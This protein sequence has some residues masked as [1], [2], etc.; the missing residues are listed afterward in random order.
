MYAGKNFTGRNFIFTLCF[1]SLI[2]TQFAYAANKS[3]QKPRKWWPQEYSV[4]RDEASGT[5]TVS[6]SYYTIVH[7][8]KKGGVITKIKYTN[9]KANNLLLKPLETSVRIADGSNVTYS[10]LHNSEPKVTHTKTDKSEIVITECSLLDK[11]GKDFG[12]KVK[13]KYEY[14]WGYIKIHKELHCQDAPQKVNR[15]TVLNTIFDPSLTKYGYREAITEQEGGGNY[16]FGT[17]QWGIMRPGT[18]FDKPLQTR[19]IPMQLLLANQGVEAIE[20]FA[21]SDLSQWDY[22][23]TGQPGTGL[24][25]I[26]QSLNPI[27][28]EVSICPVDLPRGAIELKGTYTFDYFIGMSILEAHATEPLFHKMFGREGAS[29]TP[30]DEIKRWANRGI[31]I[32]TFQDACHYYGDKMFWRDG[33]YPPYPPEEMKKMDKVIETSHRHGIKVVPYF[34]AKELHPSADEFKKH[35]QQWGTKPTDDG[36]LIHGYYG[37]DE[38]GVRMCLKSGWL[39]YLKFSIDRVLKNHKFNGA[40]F[41]WCL[42]IFCNNPLHMGKTTNNIPSDKGLGALAI[43]PTGHWDVEGLIELIEWTRQRIGPDGVLIIHD[44]QIPMLTLENFATHILAFEWGYNQVLSSFPHVSQMPLEWNLVGATSRGV[45]PPGVI[46]PKAPKR[47]NKLMALSALMTQVTVEDWAGRGK[48]DPEESKPFRIL[49]PLGDIKQYKFEDWRNTAVILN[50][51]NCISAIY[52][53]PGQAYILLANLNPEPEK[54][55]CIIKPENL[56]YA[57]PSIKSAK[58]LK[59]DKSIK[60]NKKKITNKGETINIPADT[61]VLIHILQ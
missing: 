41:D 19:H 23:M 2:M 22:Q 8:L 36:K 29:W 33:T 15:M 5:I 51:K 27:G 16:N 48:D 60:L 25:S 10:N 11:D 28:I 42:A 31:K 39:D 58:I 3:K 52:S 35:G 12:I 53:K 49:K 14:R 4:L 1:M 50:D 6:T 46:A 17:C 7:D 44:T 45:I 24:C 61:V 47:L 30:E 26:H 20:W 38:F 18:H 21:S 34:S 57:L 40:Y 55:R 32:T 37:D 56:P 13:T 9:G 59:S 54:I 43:S